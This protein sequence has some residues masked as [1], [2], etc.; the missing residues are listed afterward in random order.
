MK[1]LIKGLREFQSSYVPQH[2]ELLQELARGQ[3]PRVLFITCSDTRI[4][5]QNLQI[6]KI[7]KSAYQ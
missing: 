2:K 3:H 1:D 5:H 7:K 4:E 6:P